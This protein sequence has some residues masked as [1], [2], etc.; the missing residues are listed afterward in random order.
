[1]NLLESGYL[2]AA[3]DCSDHFMYRFTSLGADDENPIVS[4]STQE[5]DEEMIIKDHSKL[6]R[7]CPRMEHKNLEVTDQMQNLACINDMLIKDLTGDTDPQIYITCGKSNNGTLRQLTHGL[8]VLEMAVSPMPFKPTRVITLKAKIGEELDKFLIVSAVDSSLILGINEG[9]ISS[10]NDSS[11]VKGEPTVHAG[12]M[13]DG[14]YVQI[15]ETSIIHIRSHLGSTNTKW[16][17]DTGRKI[18]AACSNS[19]QV[20]I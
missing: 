4:N 2:F 18:M 9:K 17:C 14:S 15:T 10:L 7:F 19:R 5:F 12:T 20:V 16:Q 11:F 8:T 13:E 6:T 1:M 3:G